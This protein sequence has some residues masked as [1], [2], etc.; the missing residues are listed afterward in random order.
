MV[1]VPVEIP[2]TTP[3]P[4]AT[5][6]TPDALLLHAPPDTVLANVVVAPVQTADNP[7][8]VPADAED[9]TTTVN[10]AIAVPHDVTTV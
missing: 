4:A 5:A 1:A 8:M 2:V 9:P 3:V 10:V 6:A 7:E